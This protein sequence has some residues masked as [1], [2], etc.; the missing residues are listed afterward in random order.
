MNTRYEAVGVTDD[1]ATIVLETPVPV[2][3]RVRVHLYTE[4]AEPT[5]AAQDREA[6]LQQIHERQRARGHK[7]R[8]PEEVEAELRELRCEEDDEADLP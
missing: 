5:T 2:R 1:G 7:P 3:G 8:S 4:D 6:I